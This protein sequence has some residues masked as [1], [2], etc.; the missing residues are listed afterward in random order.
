MCDIFDA[1]RR[2]HW[3]YYRDPSSSRL[4]DLVAFASESIR[5][6]LRGDCDDFA[7]LMAALIR[8]IG[9]ACRVALVYPETGAAHA[10]AEV[11][12]GD[13]R[14]AYLIRDH[15]RKRYGTDY[16]YFDPGVPGTYWLTLDWGGTPPHYVDSFPGQIPIERLATA[17]KVLYVPILSYTE[18]IRG[19]W[20]VP[21]TP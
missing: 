9:G 2:P 7:V 14:N 12:A 8:A 10:L 15:I 4:G 21:T 19:V 16:V 13:E 18:A 20:P 3:T 6:G 17:R 1:I 5:I 11:Y